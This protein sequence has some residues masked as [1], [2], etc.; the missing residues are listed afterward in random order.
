MN[1]IDIIALLSSLAGL[2]TFFIPSQW[3]TK[4]NFI[5]A[6]LF[7]LSAVSIIMV[8]QYSRLRHIERV[9]RAARQLLEQKEMEFTYDGFTQAGLAFLEQNK[10]LYP[11]SYK[12][13][14]SI[15]KDQSVHEVHK[16]STIEGIIK[17]IGILNTASE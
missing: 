14:M 11:D 12:R 1:A 10:N 15:A 13:A 7:I 17:G 9:S 16:A 4:K 3:Q 2:A 5:V 8:N 6:G